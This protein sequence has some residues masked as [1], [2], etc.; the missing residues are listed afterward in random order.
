MAL[1]ATN[2]KSILREKENIQFLLRDF[3]PDLVISNHSNVFECLRKITSELHQYRKHD[4][5]TENKSLGNNTSNEYTIITHVPNKS[6][7]ALNKIIEEKD[8]HIQTIQKHLHNAQSELDNHVNL[9]ITINAIESKYAK[10]EATNNRIQ[11]EMESLRISERN[12]MRLQQ[13]MQIELQQLRNELHRAYSEKVSLQ[14]LSSELQ[15]ALEKLIE[16]KKTSV[17]LQ[18]NRGFY[19][20]FYNAP[21]PLPSTRLKKRCW[22]REATFYF[23]VL[24]SKPKL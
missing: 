23:R 8:L 16:N 13:R 4:M 1:S 10:A 5:H 15:K 9:Q 3:F 21:L 17:S 20:N 18:F 22:T 2:H 14:N 7:C 11:S 19:Y 24:K 6:N 12:S